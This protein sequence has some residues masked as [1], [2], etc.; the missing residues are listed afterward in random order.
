[1]RQNTASRNG[2][3]VGRWTKTDRG[4]QVIALT[5]NDP[6]VPGSEVTVAVAR[7]DGGT[8]TITGRASKSFRIRYGDW[9]GQKGVFVA[10]A[11]G[12][13]SPAR[14]SAAARNDDSVGPWFC[15]R[16]SYRTRGEHDQSCNN[17]DC[18]G[19]TR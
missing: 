11:N 19:G 14:R 18:Q 1:M 17:P 15:G 12:N 7:R 5:G 13:G 4:F 9:T 3:L 6:A 16:L 8:D 10:A 2:H